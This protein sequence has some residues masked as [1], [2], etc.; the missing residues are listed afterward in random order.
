MLS[1]PLRI[2]RERA[3]RSCSGS[4]NSCKVSHGPVPFFSFFP[5]KTKQIEIVSALSPYVHVFIG[6]CREK[7]LICA[8]M[9]QPLTLEEIESALA[10]DG[11]FHQTFIDRISRV[12]ANY[13]CN[14]LN[15]SSFLCLL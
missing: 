15:F 11:I 1:V 14:F 12:F 13:G 4:N 9:E 5:R 6:H 8:D 2:A 3:Q 10:N 7:L